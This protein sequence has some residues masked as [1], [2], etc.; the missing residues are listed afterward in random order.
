M[1]CHKPSVIS[2]LGKISHQD[3]HALAVFTETKRKCLIALFL[4]IGDWT[5]S[6]QALFPGPKGY[7]K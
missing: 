4:A 7:P 5:N 6:I 2:S 1:F 3:L